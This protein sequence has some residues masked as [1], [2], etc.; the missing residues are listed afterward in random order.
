MRHV[1][2]AL[3]CVPQA[4]LH[5]ENEEEPYAG[6]IKYTAIPPAK[7]FRDTRNSFAVGAELRVYGT[8]GLGCNGLVACNTTQTS[9]AGAPAGVLN[10]LSLPAGCPALESGIGT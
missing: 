10:P 4:Y 5:L 1:P 6:G 2:L 7:R 8:R 9:S 3:Y